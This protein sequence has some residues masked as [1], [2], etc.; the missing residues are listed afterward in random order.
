MPA[1]SLS[2]IAPALNLPSY[3]E[4]EVL[5]AATWLWMHAPDH[6]DLPLHALGELLLPPIRCQQYILLSSREGAACKPLAY[7][8]WANLSEEAE[9]RYLHHPAR[10]LRP[11]DWSSG[12]RMWFTDWFTPFGHAQDLYRAVRS[13]L[14]DV[15][16]RYL[17]HRGNERGMH[18]RTYRGTRVTKE[19][20]RR[21]WQE[22][23]MLASSG[24]LQAA[25]FL[26]P[27]L[28]P[29]AQ[30]MRGERE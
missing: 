30:L 24:P 25:A 16:A 3:S 27:H 26:S 8:A 23:P 12:D 19:Q 14:P 7:L 20:A 22:R 5:G 6:Q 2:I 21:W 4:L 1:A 28:P 9:S 18:V 11:R 29:H 15:C 10:G 13:L 17:D